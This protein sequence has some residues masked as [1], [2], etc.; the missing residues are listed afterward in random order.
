MKPNL[1]LK[2]ILII[3]GFLFQFQANSRNMFVKANA[4][5]YASNQSVYIKNDLELNVATSNFYLSK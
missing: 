3:A 5:I 4:Y 1:F 2:S